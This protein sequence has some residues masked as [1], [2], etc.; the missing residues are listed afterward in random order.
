MHNSSV[1][2][3]LRVTPYRNPPHSLPKCAQFPRSMHTSSNTVPQSTTFSLEVCTIPTF[4][5]HFEQHC[6]TIHHI[7]SRSMHDYSVPCTLRAKLHNNPSHSLSK[8]ARFSRFMHT[9]SNTAPR[10]T[11]F[12]PEVC[13]ITAFHAHFEQHRTAIHHILSRSVHDSS[14]SCTLR[15]KLHNNPSHSLSKYARFSRFMHTSSNTVPQSTP[16]PSRQVERGTAAGIYD[17]RWLKIKCCGELAQR[18]LPT[19]R[20]FCLY[21]RLFSVMKKWLIEVCFHQPFLS[22]IPNSPPIPLLGRAEV[23]FL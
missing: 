5:A 20:D 7:L 21:H 18:A 9:S 11:T 1:S 6:T 2:C 15:V 13:T 14:V 3:T 23:G 12:P 17:L 19:A 10:S 8:Y 22:I 16:I 4:H